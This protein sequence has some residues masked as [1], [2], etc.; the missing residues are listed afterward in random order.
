MAKNKNYEVSLISVGFIDSSLHYGPFSHN[1]W[2]ACNESLIPIC[3]HMRT[4]TLLNGYN[5]FLTVVKGNN[6]HSEQLGYL[7]NCNSFYTT[8]P[9]SSS[10]NAI[11]TVY[12]Q[13]F[14]NKTRFS[15]QIFVFGLARSNNNLL[16]YAGI[17]FKSSFLFQ[18]EKQ[19][20]LFLQKIEDD[21]CK[22]TIIQKA[23]IKKVYYDYTP[24]LKHFLDDLEKLQR[25]LKKEYEKNIVV[26][27]QGL[28]K[29]N[30]L[31]K[32]LEEYFLE[33]NIDKSKRFTAASMLECL[34]RKIEEGELDEDEIPKLQTIQGWIA[35]YSAQYRQK[36]A[37]KS[38]EISSNNYP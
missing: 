21:I 8:E 15:V 14:H 4:M 17:G 26:N 22:V 3:L 31:W 25:Y 10:T 29:Y 12:Q 6:E 11:S 33:G 30:S 37:E 20:C 7:C 35:R 5:F 18:L 23:E 32:L 38:I 24:D 34:K 27:N 1:W 2:T 19:H 13:I 36:M 28:T 9:S 16:E